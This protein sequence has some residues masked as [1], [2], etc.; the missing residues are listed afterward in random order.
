MRKLLFSG[1]LPPKSTHGVSYSNKVNLNFLKQRFKIFIA[2]EIVPLRSHKK[3]TFGK[4]KNLTGRV[5][6]IFILTIANRFSYFYIV[7]STSTAGAI[8]TLVLMIIFKCFNRGRIIVH[9]HRGDLEKFINES[10]LNA[11]LFKLVTKLTGSYIVLSGQIK[12]YIETNYNKQEIYVIENTISDEYILQ[13]PI[14]S[15]NKK[16][17]NFVYISNYIEE[18]G[19]LI[20]L[21]VFQLLPDNFKLECFGN[22]TDQQLKEKIIEFG[23]ANNIFINEPIYGESKF[24]KINQADALILPSYNEGKPLVLLEAMSVGTPFI[25]SNVGFIHEIPYE[26]YPY[27]YSPNTEERLKEVILN[28]IKDP[29]ISEIGKELY[30]RYYSLFS[31]KEHN[32]KILEIFK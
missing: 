13:K 5:L 22:F 21:N 6:K 17:Y 28:F 19:I 25:A 24:E 26:N 30:K 1:E 16:D 29:T 15:N 11:K 10:Q 2:E 27:L 23:Q 9:I 12:T 4:L 3:I 32:S 18:K 14:N 8:K 7:F 20:L 31:Q